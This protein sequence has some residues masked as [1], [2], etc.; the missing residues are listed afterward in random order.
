MSNLSELLPAG[1]GGKSVDFV[2]SGTL[3]NGQTVVLNSDGTV[4]AITGQTGT[5]VVFESAATSYVS[6]V[7]D[8]A[9]NKVVV[10]YADGGNASYGTAVV[11]TVSGT[12]IS[13]GTVV[14]Y[15]SSESQFNVATFDSNANKTV[16]AYRDGGLSNHGYAI[17]GTVSGTSISF[18]TAAAF[19]AG[20]TT[21]LGIG[22]DSTA[23][24]VVIAYR[25]D[26]NSDYGTARVGTVSGTGISYGAEAVFQTSQT[27][28]HQVAYD[29]DQNKT[30]I[31]YAHNGSSGY[32]TAN[33]CTLSGTSISFGTAVVFKTAN[34]EAMAAVYDTSA[35]KVVIPYSITGAGKGVVGTVSGTSISFG[36]EA[37]FSS[38]GSTVKS[39]AFNSTDNKTVVAFVEAVTTFDGFT[40]EG[41]VSGTSVSFNTAINFTDPNNADYIST[42]YDSTA[43]RIVFSY[44][45]TGN[46]GYGTAVVFDA[47]GIPSTNFIGITDAAISDT[48]SGSVTI[49]GGI[50]ANVTGLTANATYYVQDD[51]T[52]STTTSSVL[53]GKALSSTS[54][55]LDYTT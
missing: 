43:N 17:V 31:A 13:F 48:A 46:S 10:F 18:G 20:S 49:K 34:V 12:A 22:F 40:V 41:T 21:N 19:N 4:S 29:P 27:S 7:F 15:N 8:T 33:V 37:T 28:L 16:T 44:E 25:D 9:A 23:N 6:S 1:G 24:K 26:G 36:A 2:A 52:L 55:N 39:A 50:S 47:S 54:I 35:N 42:A 38:T 3:S 53:A 11:G 5:A 51:G 45:D 32:G 14:V 30:I